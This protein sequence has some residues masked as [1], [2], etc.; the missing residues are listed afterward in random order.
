MIDK[1]AA[2]RI[3][4]ETAKQAGIFQVKNLVNGKIFLGSS[5][6]IHGPLN[7]LRFELPVGRFR[8]AGLQKEWN[9]YGAECFSFDI[10]EIV[11]NSDDPDFNIADELTL[12]EQIW[13]E[14]LQPFGEKGYNE[15][16]DIRWSS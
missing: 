15:N 1:K 6:N 13:V 11:R 16:S 5:L 7:R 2:K 8:V 9:E 3:Y 12:L 4:K 14:K 10:L